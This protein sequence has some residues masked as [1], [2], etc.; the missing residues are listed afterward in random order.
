[1]YPRVRN[2]NVH[3]SPPDPRDWQYVAEPSQ[4]PREV[5]LRAWD[6]PVE[7]QGTLGSCV[8]HALT[9]CYELM[10]KKKYPEK[11]IELSRLFSYYHTRFLED[12]V[13]EDA[14][15]IYLRNAL[16]AGNK[17]GICSENFWV[18]DIDKFTVQPSPTAY[19]DA[20]QRKISKYTALHTQEDALE[21]LNSGYPI[22]IGMLIHESFMTITDKRPTMP[23]PDEYDY[24]LGG[25]SVSIVGYSLPYQQFLIK[26]SFGPEW[27]ENGY[28]WMP[29]EYFKNYVFEKWTFEI[30]D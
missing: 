26:N 18:Y 29:F 30:S 19:M 6:S 17:F 20:C 3:Q 25:H 4:L 28:C 27:G 14:G 5:D 9:S 7:D 21:A 15:V 12:S 16:K 8:S 2:F 13:N 10:T 1:M 23:M 11:F 24:A 22:V